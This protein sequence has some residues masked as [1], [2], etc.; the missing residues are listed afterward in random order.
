M[1]LNSKEDIY[2]FILHFYFHNKF[3]KIRGFVKISKNKYELK[4]IFS[5][6]FAYRYQSVTNCRLEHIKCENAQS[7]KGLIILKILLVHI[8]RASNSIKVNLNNFFP[9]SP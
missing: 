4:F 9:K 1:I 3:S 2:K 7:A 8:H 5:L 6:I